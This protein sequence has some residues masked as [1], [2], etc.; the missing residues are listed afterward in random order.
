MLEGES[1]R[2]CVRMSRICDPTI[3]P[4]ANRGAESG[5]LKPPGHVLSTENDFSVK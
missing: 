5:N 3:S 2:K 4:D 1:C